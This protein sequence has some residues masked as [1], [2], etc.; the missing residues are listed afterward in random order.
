MLITN[1][2]KRYHLGNA[3][4]VSPNDDLVTKYNWLKS[5]DRDA[6]MGALSATNWR[7]L[8]LTPGT[9]TLT[10]GWDL[11]T[12][13]IAVVSLTP[14]T[15]NITI[16]Q[17][18]CTGSGYPANPPYVI[19]QSADYVYLAGFKILQTAAG[20]QQGFSLFITVSNTN[21]F[22]DYMEFRQTA[23]AGM[24]M[25]VAA[26]DAAVTLGGIWR[27]CKGDGWF[28]QNFHPDKTQEMSGEYYDCVC[29]G[30]YGFGCD[31]EIIKGKFYRC[32][33]GDKSFGGCATF[34][35]IIHAD[36]YFED[37]EAGVT[38]F[39]PGESCGGT[40]VRCKAGQ[41]SFGGYMTGTHPGT[42]SGY[43]VD[44][45]GLPDT[46]G[47]FGQGD[48]AATLSGALI[49]CRMGSVADYK[50]GTS[51]AGDCTF[52]GVIKNC[53]PWIPTVCT[54]SRN[55]YPFDNGQTYTNTGAAAAVELTLPDAVLG[56]KFTF[57]RTEAGAGKDVKI[58]PQSSDAIVQLNG[59]D[60]G[61]GDSY[62]N[63]ADAYGEVTLEC[64][65]ADKWQVTREIG[66]WAEA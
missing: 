29:D 44:C 33:S 60:L 9:Y 2:A 53:H 37:C 4:I 51:K 57:V 32:K 40:F 27:H 10:S 50:A 55:I 25:C 56:L 30:D 59:T 35:H 64:K 46:Y 34:G 19:K 39:C 54:A 5:S 20:V 14:H 26:Y 23:A 49:R 12:S 13:Y 42:F 43:A 18:A 15:P 21:S 45:V 52:S 11:D 17:R 22:Y 47:V 28:I 36:A 41:G 65:V 16:V 66:T 38:S 58:T 7:V 8:I 48:A 6:A 1:I 63:T 24:R 61:N 62:Q 31:C 3:L